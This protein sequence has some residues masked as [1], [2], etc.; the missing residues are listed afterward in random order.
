MNLLIQLWHAPNLVNPSGK[1]TKRGTRSKSL[2]VNSDL[3]GISEGGPA[4]IT[5]QK[6]V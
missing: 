5:S 2:A 4:H 3:L 1:S 6:A